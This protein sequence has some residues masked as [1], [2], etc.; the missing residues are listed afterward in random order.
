MCLNPIS[1][2]NPSK[3]VSLSYKDRY[4]LQ[5]PCGTCAECQTT[6]SNQWNY[7][8]YYE[9]TDCIGSGG[10]VYYDTLSYDAQ[11]LPHI[12]DHFNDLATNN[13]SCFNKKHITNFL[14]RLRIN[15]ERKRG[16]KLR[17]FITSEYGHDA[18]YIDHRGRVRKG[19]NRPH[20]H[21]LAF[22]YGKIA[23]LEFSRE[24]ATAWTYGRTDG[25]PYRPSGY[26]TMHNV[27]ATKTPANILRTSSYISKY[28]QKSCEFKETI[29]KRIAAVMMCYAQ[30]FAPNKEDE[31]LSSPAAYRIRR[32]ISSMVSQFHRQSLHY[33]ETALGEMDIAQVFRD[34]YLLMPSAKTINV[35]VAIP[36]YY[37]RKLFYRLVEI[38][39]CKSWQLNDLGRRYQSTRERYNIQRLQSQM[40]CVC[41][42][43]HLNFDCA[44]LA[45]YVYRDRGRIKASSPSECIEQKLQQLDLFNYVTMTD[46]ENLCF[47]GLVPEFVGNQQL[48]Y[49]VNVMPPHI[50]IKDF[51]QKYVILEPEREKE[52]SIIY[53]YT[54]FV[55]KGKQDAY[56]LRQH[57]SNV[58]KAFV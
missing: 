54:A 38:D 7:R 42:E 20:Y 13:F 52:L 48:G 3:Y 51:I 46:K 34:G 36:T 14:K 6:L 44:R 40:E 56:R 12:K 1:V 17:Y 22:V 8:T 30:R 15:V 49:T 53:Y 33:G 5:V 39:G 18:N 58:Y 29:D 25:Q 11:S 2:I 28:V 45:R 10:F 37:K 43:H 50:S 31:W 35:K 19:T 41:I 26:V 32:K 16:V 57:L 21:L 55:D 24:V 23:P 27:I 47:R 9:F 4:L